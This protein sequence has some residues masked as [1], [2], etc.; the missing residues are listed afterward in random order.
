M[1]RKV[2]AA[3]VA[4][5]FLYI[6]LPLLFPVAMGAVLAVLFVPW[7]EYLERRKV[8][9]SLASALLTLGITLFF[10]L[11]SALVIYIF[12]KEALTQIDAIRRTAATQG[13]ASGEVGWVQAMLETPRIHHLLEKLTQWLP[14]DMQ[15]VGE[16]AQDLVNATGTKL[17]EGLG[18][19][20][21]QLPGIVLALAVIGVSVYF[22][23]I[24]GRRLVLFLRRNSVF[25]AQ[26][27][28]QLM[29]TLAGT[30]R[31]V[32]LASIIS[33]AAQGLFVFVV[34]LA[35]GMPNAALIGML[36]FVASFIPVVG[37]APITFS[38]V[39]HQ[40]FLDRGGSAILLLVTALV[41]L[42]LDNLI[43]PLFLRGSANLHP[44]LAFVAAFGGLQSL[45]FSGVFLG[46][47]IAAMF[48]VTVQ[49]LVYSD[50]PLK[51]EK[52]LL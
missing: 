13:P 20:A 3:A 7:L 41:V 45:G 22:F 48:M 6:S 1:G 37:S 19:L 17:A 21:T 14:I 46:P 52:P 47:I 5:L 24:D 50:A 18:S 51:P 39:L 16:T 28:D 10:V 31:S 42:L 29:Y 25:S 12:S 32:I 35:I 9:T 40:F 44:L 30:C 11:P 36:V 33:G 15:Q 38:L 49:I 4:I 23:L 26:Q 8:S 2:F 27:T 43:R 34:C